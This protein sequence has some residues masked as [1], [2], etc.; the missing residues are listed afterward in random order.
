MPAARLE[1]RKKTTITIDEKLFDRLMSYPGPSSLSD[2]IETLCEYA[3]QM[4]AWMT[5]EEA[6]E[7][8]EAQAMKM[9]GMLPNKR[10]K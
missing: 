3:L 4:G 9:L 1:P 7:I 10:R 2:R 5:P 6:R 8:A